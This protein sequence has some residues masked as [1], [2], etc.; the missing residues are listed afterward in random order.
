MQDIRLDSLV[1]RFERC[2]NPGRHLV[3]F[4]NQL[5][6]QSINSANDYAV[7]LICLRHIFEKFP[8]AK[9]VFGMANA[10]VDTIINDS[11]VRRQAFVIQDS[12]G[13][14][15]NQSINKSINQTW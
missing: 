6:I 8:D 5:V 7:G 10:R 1:G 4:I 9:G 15:I 12:I 2:R 11:R 13:T 3:C 14:Y